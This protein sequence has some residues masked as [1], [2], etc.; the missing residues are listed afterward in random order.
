MTDKRPPH[1]NNL[2]GRQITT[3]PV[4]SAISRRWAWREVPVPED[5]HLL[6]IDD[7]VSVLKSWARV[8][9]ETAFQVHTAS[10]DTAAR[11]VLKEVDIQVVLLDLKMPG[12]SGLVLLESIRNEYPETA[13]II[14]TG[15]G[16]LQDAFVASRLGAEDFLEKTISPEMLRIR[17][18]QLYSRW[19]RQ[20]KKGRLQYRFDREFGLE[21]LIGLS[22]VMLELKSLILRAATSNASILI[23]GETG[24]GKE[25]C[26]R[27]IHHCS[28]RA[29]QP[30]V[31]VD[32][33]AIS[34]SIA[35]SEW[36]G[37]MQGAFTGAGH[38]HLGLIRS[39]HRGTL[40]LD[41][42]GEL[43]AS[44]QVKLL[45]TLQEREVRPV[46]SSQ[47]F[48]VD[49]RIVAA[50][51][52]ALAAAVQAGRFRRDLYYRL[53]T[54]PLSVP[55]LRERRDD[56]PSLVEHFLRCPQSENGVIKKIS[57]TALNLL[58]NRHWPG[59]VRELQNCI[60]RAVTLSRET[61]LTDQDFRP[62]CGSEFGQYELCEIRRPTDQS[63][64]DMEKVAILK[65]LNNSG[66]NRRKAAEILRISEATLYRKLKY[67]RATA[68]DLCFGESRDPESEASPKPDKNGAAMLSN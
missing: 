7:E 20:E 46:G 67:Y 24:T 56:I 60:H 57:P 39:A 38:A 50:S 28:S 12:M 47:R 26:A 40:F 35:E 29:D 25:L 15:Q 44:M 63:L 41:E 52:R 30:F 19:R 23:T 27:A 68:V 37:H 42:V 5:F 14:L 31:P 1:F 21:P 32:C 64:A 2:P 65:A 53:N 58:K 4:G 45:R 54:I 43:S 49:I 6:L 16:S 51:N 9:A 59:N 36:F 18:E 48:P 10:D 11:A 55:S 3:A 66:G 34:E 33:G 22:T 8:F 62:D 61:E 13:V 17:I